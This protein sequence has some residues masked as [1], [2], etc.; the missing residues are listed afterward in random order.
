MTKPDALTTPTGAPPSAVPQPAAARSKRGATVLFDAPGPRAR[1]RITI[2]SAITI[3]FIAAAVAFAVHQFADH[4]QLGAAKWE[5]FTQWPIWRFL[6]NGL[7]GTLQAAALTA[8]LGSALGMVMALGRLSR[9]RVIH[10]AATAYIEIART[11]PVLLMI[12]VTLFALPAYGINLPLVWKLVAPLTVANSAAFAEIFRAG[13][14][15]LPRGQNE[16]ALSIGLTRGQA[17]RLV[18]MPQ[19]IR[20]V[21]PSVVSQLVSLTKD[22]SLGYVVSFS[23]LLFKGQVLS[24]FNHLLIQTFL[25]VTLIYLVVNGTLSSVAHRLQRRTGPR[26][27]R[28]ARAAEA[29]PPGM[30]ATPMIGESQRD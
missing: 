11:L 24:T 17:M 21:T 8:V 29:L 22:T 27:G 2:A 25:V 18:V 6:L 13:I 10:Y 16:A 19:A 14:L 4:G 5:P 23:E 9:V 15:G 30:P 3:A 20:M 12:Y 26:S 1:R 28:A 7:L